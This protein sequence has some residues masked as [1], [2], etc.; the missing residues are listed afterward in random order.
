MARKLRLKYPEACYHVINRGNC[1][2]E[3]L[4]Q[5]EALKL[6]KET[7]LRRARS[8]VGGSTPSWL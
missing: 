3:S 2:R 6:S 5:K 8:T 4:S 7:F 1:R